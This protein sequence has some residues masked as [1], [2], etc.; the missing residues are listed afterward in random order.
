MRS[1]SRLN[2]EDDGLLERAGGG[3][4]LG[5]DVELLL[6]AADVEL[7]LD[8]VVGLDGRELEML[9]AALQTWGIVGG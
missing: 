5:L 4:G 6:A 3:A 8:V 1:S 2:D 9:V 7:E